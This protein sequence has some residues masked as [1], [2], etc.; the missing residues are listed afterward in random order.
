MLLPQHGDL[1]SDRLKLKDPL[2]CHIRPHRDVG[3]TPESEAWELAG[4]VHAVRARG[5]L[6]LRSDLWLGMV[7]RPALAHGK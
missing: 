5:V 4:C 1:A 3:S 7:Q 2:S 6:L